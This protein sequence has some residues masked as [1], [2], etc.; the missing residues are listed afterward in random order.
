VQAAGPTVSTGQS[1]SRVIARH[2]YSASVRLEAKWAQFQIV[3]AQLRKGSE[4]LA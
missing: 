2:L 3:L 1:G 4:L